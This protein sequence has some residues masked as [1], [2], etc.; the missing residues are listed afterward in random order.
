[1]TDTDEILAAIHARA[2]ELEGDD[3]AHFGRG[4]LYTAAAIVGHAE[5][6]VSL[7]MMLHSMS[8]T[9]ASAVDEGLHE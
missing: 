2:D 1:M 7:A 6:D 4:L 5:G 3:L 8:V 9:A